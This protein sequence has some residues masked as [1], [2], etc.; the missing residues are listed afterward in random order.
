MWIN[1]SPSRMNKD[2]GELTPNLLT[3]DKE[4]IPTPIPPSGERLNL[5]SKCINYCTLFYYGMQY[6]SPRQL[7]PQEGHANK[8]KSR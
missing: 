6:S 7:G 5:Q 1:C 8:K 4:A 3:I 2:T